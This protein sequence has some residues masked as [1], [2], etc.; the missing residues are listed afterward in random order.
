MTTTKSSKS[1]WDVL[2]VVAAVLTIAV[3]GA[4]LLVLLLSL[5]PFILAHFLCEGLSKL[6][7][8]WVAQTEKGYYIISNW[9]GKR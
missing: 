5:S 9:W 4:L 1:P 3:L 2:P 8:W 7:W 6:G